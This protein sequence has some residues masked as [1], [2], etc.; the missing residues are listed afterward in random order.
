MH[1][2]PRF[3]LLWG[4]RSALL[5]GGALHSFIWLVCPS[6]CALAKVRDQVFFIS[7]LSQCLAWKGSQEGSI[8]TVKDIPA[9]LLAERGLL[10]S[11]PW[12]LRP[13]TGSRCRAP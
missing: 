8:A 9:F 6:S 12:V 10:L 7:V 4:T 5:L 3:V 11:S 2:S 1:T 13:V